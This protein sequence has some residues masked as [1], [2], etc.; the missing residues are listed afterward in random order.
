M[1]F[2]WAAI[3]LSHAANR[4]LPQALQ[5]ENNR[6]RRVR[7]SDCGLISVFFPGERTTALEHRDEGKKCIKRPGAHISRSLIPNNKPVT[8]LMTQRTI[9]FL[10]YHPGS[11]FV[12]FRFSHANPS[13]CSFCT[14]THIDQPLILHLVRINEKP[15]KGK[16]SYALD[17]LWRAYQFLW[18]LKAQLQFQ[19]FFQ[20]QG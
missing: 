7:T 9:T 14:Y 19:E 10:G 1:E 11:H 13:L 20:N 12:E 16:A 18:L 8:D 17:N 4:L 5:L 6:V 15:A 2:S 3:I